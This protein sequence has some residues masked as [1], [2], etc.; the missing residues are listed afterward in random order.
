MP[1]TPVDIN[2]RFARYPGRTQEI[3]KRLD[4]PNLEVRQHNILNDA[5]DAPWPELV[6]S[7]LLTFDAV[8]ARR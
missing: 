5:P 4:L 3:V 6:R 8:L 2:I 7:G 1:G